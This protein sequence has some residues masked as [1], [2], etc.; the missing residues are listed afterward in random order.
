MY[1]EGDYGQS[2]FRFLIQYLK[3]TNGN[4]TSRVLSDI[5][6]VNKIK[7]LFISSTFNKQVF[8]DKIV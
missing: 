2:K 5:S 8:Y 7:G 4:L 1:I 3:K 6:L